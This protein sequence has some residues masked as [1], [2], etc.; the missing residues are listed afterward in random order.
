MQSIVA[1]HWLSHGSLPQAELLLGK[2]ASFLPPA[3][4]N[5]VSLPVYQFS[6]KLGKGAPTGAGLGQ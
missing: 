4:S 2:G 6:H 5:V 3:E 1:S